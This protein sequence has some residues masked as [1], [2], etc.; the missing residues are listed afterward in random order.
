MNEKNLFPILLLDQFYSRIGKI[1]SSNDEILKSFLIRYIE[2]C[3]LI[4]YTLNISINYLIM[5]T[6][7]S[8][9]Y[10]KF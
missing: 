10:E 4:E 9:M 5:V 1:Y 6:L 7:N 2:Y 3:K 8:F